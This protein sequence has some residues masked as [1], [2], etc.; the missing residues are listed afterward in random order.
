[1]GTLFIG[2]G[3]FVGYEMMAH[4]LR[5]GHHLTVIDLHP[6]PD[7]FRGRVE[8]LKVDR[9]DGAELRARLAG[10]KFDAVV[11]NIAFA[12]QQVEKLVQALDGRTNRLLLTSTVDIYP[13]NVPLAFAEHQAKLDPSEQ[14]GTTGPENYLRGKRGCEKALMA[15]GLPWTVIRPA[16]VVGRRD[17]QAPPPRRAFV[18]AGGPSRALFFPCRLLDGGPILLRRDDEGVFKLIWVS[19][20]AA[21]VCLLLQSQ[22]AV[23]QAYNATGD[24]L[25][26]PER[27]V[28]ALA[29][30]AGRVPDIV[31]VSTGQ[32]AQAGLS[33]YQAPY[34]RGP[35]WSVADNQKL[36]RL[37]WRSSPPALWMADL[38]EAMPPHFAR[39]YYDRRLR[40]IA[41]AHRARRLRGSLPHV[42]RAVSLATP[43]IFARTKGR[44][45]S[46]AWNQWLGRVFDGDADL[47]GKEMTPFRGIP[48][49]RFGLG[50]YRGDTDAATDAKY[51]DAIVHAV[52]HGIN[53]IDT[54]INYRAMQAER[55]VGR[56]LKRLQAEGF[57]RSMVLLCTKGGYIAH[58][59]AN[60]VP[61]NRY[62]KESYVDRGLITSA[63]A[64]RRHS[65][66]PEFI[67][68]QIDQSLNNLCVKHI[69]IYYLHNPEVALEFYDRESFYKTLALTFAVLEQAV[70]DER[71]GSYGLATWQG[72]LSPPSDKKHLSLA[73][74]VETARSVAGTDHHFKA[75]QMPFSALRPA[76]RTTASQEVDGKLVSAFDAA[77]L[78]G[79]YC[80]TSASAGQ[81]HPLED[82]LVRRL[83]EKSPA[84]RPRGAML[85]IAKS[86][87]GV[88][89]ALIGMREVAHVEEAI[90]VA[91]MPS[92]DIGDIDFV[93]DNAT[94]AAA[95]TSVV[96]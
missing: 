23:G 31:R 30:T 91:K 52:K 64:A 69:D 90:E 17:N 74:A 27:L 71:V 14:E 33:D 72:L 63:D 10:R 75:V 96:G 93:L 11:D 68:Y 8:W 20:L 34:G 56:A 3:F 49:S 88:G 80:F 53:V 82:K 5:D 12:P 16:L 77:R 58:D 39:P 70:A 24:E 61:Y 79:L 1:M 57:D 29:Q 94:V 22:A 26:T 87:P 55:C 59:F 45:D 51:I 36:R 7:E 48:L 41:L 54:A 62:V 65:I 46:A 32:L 21:A 73:R 92:F 83:R 44:L 19:D 67:R 43:S 2:G 81:E 9:N 76:A 66:R 50:T 4:L 60:N 95:K 6:P 25:W 42:E 47:A 85:R 78:L 37:G 86:V 18:T 38:M 35:A 89:T 84:L 13:K 28:M 40:E 15:S